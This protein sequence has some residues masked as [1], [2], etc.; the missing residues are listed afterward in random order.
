MGAAGGQLGEA[1]EGLTLLF[2]VV[3]VKEV[4]HVDW[5]RLLQRKSSAISLIIN[6]S[7]II[8]GLANP[9]HQRPVV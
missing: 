5:F 4:G 1:G 2:F 6:Y 8:L 3:V 7:R 9:S